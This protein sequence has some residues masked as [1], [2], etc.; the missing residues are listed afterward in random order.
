MENLNM[1]SNVAMVE[2]SEF[3][4]KVNID[5]LVLPSKLIDLAEI[6]I[7]DIKQ[8]PIEEEK[9][10]SIFETGHD[11]AVEKKLQM[12]GNILK[13]YEELDKEKS[14]NSRT[15]FC[16]RRSLKIRQFLEKVAK[17]VW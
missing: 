15:D 17:Y 12:E 1:Q 4:K 10:P 6:E 7:D 3:E 16:L 11:V 14:E 13:L 5:D 9:E 2:N 8:E